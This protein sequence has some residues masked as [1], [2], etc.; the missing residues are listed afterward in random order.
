MFFLRKAS[1]L[2]GKPFGL[3]KLSIEFLGTGIK[4]AGTSFEVTELPLVLTETS[5]KTA[6]TS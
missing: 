1:K 3:A 5:M 6:E 4:G 2:S